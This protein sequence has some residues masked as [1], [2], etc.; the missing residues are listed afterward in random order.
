MTRDGE[1]ITLRS[2][3]G[4]VGESIVDKKG[5]WS[6][7][8]S[9][10]A[11]FLSVALEPGTLLLLVALGLLY[12][13]SGKE[14]N[15]QT[16]VLIFLLL[17]IASVVLGGRITKKWIEL[18]EG[19][20]VVAR[21]KSAVRSLMLQLRSIAALENRMRLFRS[22][23][24]EIEEQPD[25]VKRNYEE[26]IRTCE[27]LQEQ[28]VGAIENWTDIVPEASIKSQIGVISDLKVAIGEREDQLESLKT[29]L[30]DTEGK[31]KK[32]NTSLRKQIIDGEEQIAALQ[33]ELYKKK[34]DIGGLLS[35]G[36][37]ASFF[38]PISLT[39]LGLSDETLRGV[40]PIS[41][42]DVSHGSGIG[43][44]LADIPADDKK[45]G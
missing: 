34:Y 36:A 29:E 9:R 2:T 26:A 30:Q 18:S 14:N 10:W 20:L 19:D 6:G 40:R 28:T 33:D 37:A 45:N 7:L 12:L 43:E 1:I 31:S 27:S 11:T 16:S 24:S 35:Q 21:G 41:V 5:F 13:Y 4:Y 3:D 42:T 44:L 8:G 38:K 15:E 22:A 25:V 32:E 39:G 23:E 17:T